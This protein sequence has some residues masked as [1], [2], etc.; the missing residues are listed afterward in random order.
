MTMQL[1]G[2]FQLERVHTRRWVSIIAVV[3]P[4]ATVVLVA[5]WFVRVYVAPATVLIANPPPMVAELQP[6]AAS[7]HAQIEAPEAAMAEPADPPT[8]DRT[9]SVLPMFATLALVPPALGG[10]PSAYADPR[11]DASAAPSVMAGETGDSEP[12]QPIAGP[13]P[14]PRAKPHG[15]A[16]RLASAV[17]LP[18]AR[19]AEAGAAVEDLPPAI[20]RHGIP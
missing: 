8:S 13:V 3:I 11:P 15:R 14:L 7:V 5:T 4:V 1:E 20:D 12:G 9:G 2:N 17:P 6:A 19:P 16:A 18:R 10:A